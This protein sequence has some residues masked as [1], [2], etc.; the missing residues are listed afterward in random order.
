MYNSFNRTR[1]TTYYERSTWRNW[2]GLQNNLLHFLHRKRNKQLA[3]Y[4]KPSHCKIE[5]QWR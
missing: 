2:G 1:V 3:K 5:V 4:L